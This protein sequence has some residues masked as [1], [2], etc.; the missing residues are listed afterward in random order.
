MASVWIAAF[1]F[2]NW[3]VLSSPA[4]V[5]FLLATVDTSIGILIIALSLPP[6]LVL[7]VYLLIRHGALVQENR[8]QGKELQA[9]RSL[10]ASAET[11]RITEL[12]ARIHDEIAGL[13]KRLQ[14]GIETVRS[15]LRDTERSIAA[16]LAEMDDRLLRSGDPD[17]PAP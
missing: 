17:T 16:T 2:L 4:K 8:R 11:S 7:I 12:G 5:H 10:A 14:V 3:Q 6:T 13:D 1:V 9:Q 15:E